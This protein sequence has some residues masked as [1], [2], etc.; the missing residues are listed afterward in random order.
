V[1]DH[2]ARDRDTLLFTAREFMRE[3]VV[4]IRKADEV[5]HLRYELFDLILGASP[6][7]KC[8]G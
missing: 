8:E 1:V 7:F 5:E 4:F 2:C 3:V 6:Y